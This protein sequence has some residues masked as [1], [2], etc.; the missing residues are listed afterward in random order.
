MGKWGRGSA[1]SAPRLS[2]S[3]DSINRVRVHFSNDLGGAESRSPLPRHGPHGGCLGVPE[4]YHFASSSIRSFLFGR[5][6][7]T[8]AVVVKGNPCT[9]MLDTVMLQQNPQ[10][11]EI[12][13]S[14]KVTRS[15]CS[16][17]TCSFHSP[18][19]FLAG[20]FATNVR[21][22]AALH[23]LCHRPRR[24]TSQSQCRTVGVES[25]S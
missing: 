7:L 9:A 5:S 23:Y 22:L 2:P 18:R 15:A 3:Q 11:D 20:N 17:S 21:R 12:R 14:R 4:G 8:R 24:L 16:H 13:A 25:A 6:R 10:V 1:K 19:H